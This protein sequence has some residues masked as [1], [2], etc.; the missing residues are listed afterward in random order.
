MDLIADLS[1][2][3]LILLS[4]IYNTTPNKQIIMGCVLNRAKKTDLDRSIE[5]EMEKVESEKGDGLSGKD[6]NG[7]VDERDP[8]MVNDLIIPEASED[9]GLLR[10]SKKSDQKNLFDQYM[11]Q[12]EIAEKSRVF[13]FNIF[14]IF[15]FSKK[16]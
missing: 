14:F 11:S 4:N 7:G 3:I 12:E 16:D 1:L 9:Q 15:H 8:E 5:K 6:G 10:E 2:I 13:Y